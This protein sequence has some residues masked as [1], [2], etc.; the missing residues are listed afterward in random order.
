MVNDGLITIGESDIGQCRT[1]QRSD[2]VQCRTP[3]GEIP[4]SDRTI[5]KST[6]SLYIDK[7]IKC[8]KYIFIA[9]GIDVRGKC[10]AG[11]ILV[12]NRKIL[13]IDE[14]IGGHP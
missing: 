3:Y 6:G 9:N 2:I 10:F 1:R 4:M 12:S 13:W 8:K 11:A 14:G 7:I 5:A